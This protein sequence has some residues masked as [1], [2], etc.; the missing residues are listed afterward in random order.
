MSTSD[1]AP[2]G[3]AP[4]AVL[5][6][7]GE[8]IALS[9]HGDRTSAR[10]LFAALW[11]EIGSDGDALHHCALAHAMADVQ[12]DPREELAWDLRALGAADALTDARLAAAGAA[13]R[14]AGLYPSLHLNLGEV[15]R[16]LGDTTAARRHLDLGRR[17]AGAL[18][19]DGYGQMVA[20]GL[21]RLA[22]R[23]GGAQAPSVTT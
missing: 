21:D 19:D 13:G 6:R 12:D 14:V 4:D 1:G 22:E 23:L 15:Y 18:P 16:R 20:S 9:Q 7:I 17:A 10:A 3:P 2:G 8:G 5:A 11:Q